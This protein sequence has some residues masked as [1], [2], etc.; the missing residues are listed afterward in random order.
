MRH[1]APRSEPWPHPCPRTPSSPPCGRRTPAS[2]KFPAGAPTAAPGTV[3]GARCTA[4]SSTTPRT[5]GT[6]TTVKL[7]W[8]GTPV[9]PGPLC[10]AVIAKDA[11]V[12]LVGSGRANHA[13]GGDGD[14]LRA[15]IAE[16]RLPPVRKSDTDGNSHFYGFECV[17]LGDGRDPWPEAQ[18]E[19]VERAAAAVCRHHGWSERSVIGHHEWRPGKVDPRGFAMDELRER[20]RDRLK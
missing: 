10:H 11:R 1:R 16:K 3:P 17:N 19:A 4:W 13:G 8:N 9:L 6:D 14:V 15:V 20:I 12:H 18:L 2:S 5:A 7:C